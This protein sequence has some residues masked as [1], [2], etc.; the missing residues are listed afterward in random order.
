MSEFHVIESKQSFVVWANEDTTEGRGCVKVVAVC[1]TEATARRLA[2]GKDVQ[3]TD[4]Q[5]MELPIFLLGIPGK[6][7]ITSNAYWYGPLGPNQVVR[8]TKADKHEEGRLAEERAKRDRGEKAL[9]RAREL[10]LSEEDI[11]ALREAWK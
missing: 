8:P 2:K 6:R 1:E 10:G 9:Q 3:G 5:V 11:A 4:G 7:P